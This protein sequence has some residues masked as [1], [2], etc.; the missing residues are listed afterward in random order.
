[1]KGWVIRLRHGDEWKG[2]WWAW[3]LFSLGAA[4]G[5]V[6]LESIVLLTLMVI[7]VF[8]AILDHGFE[9]IQNG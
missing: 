5:Y 9:V 6:L 7:I 8:V 1:M 4:V 3:G 2:C